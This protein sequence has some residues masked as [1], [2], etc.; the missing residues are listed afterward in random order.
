MTSQKNRL[1]Y[2]LAVIGLLTWLVAFIRMAYLSGPNWLVNDLGV[3]GAVLL[4]LAVIF[5]WV[6]KDSK[7]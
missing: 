5:A 3:I 1:V 6:W 2:T 7:D 4:L